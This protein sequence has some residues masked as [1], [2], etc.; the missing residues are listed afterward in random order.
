[1]KGG[2]FLEQLEEYQLLKNDSLMNLI[3]HFKEVCIL[4]QIDGQTDKKTKQCLQVL[5]SKY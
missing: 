5:T 2:R 3:S 4:R 1:V